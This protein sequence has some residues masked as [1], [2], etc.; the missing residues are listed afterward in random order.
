MEVPK[1]IIDKMVSTGSA[2][3]EWVT[4]SV[5]N[6]IEIERAPSFAEWV[7]AACGAFPAREYELL[8]LKTRFLRIRRWKERQYPNPMRSLW[9]VRICCKRPRHRT[10]NQSDEL[11]PP[12]ATSQPSRSTRWHWTLQ[13]SFSQLTVENSRNPNVLHSPHGQ[14]DDAQRDW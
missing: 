7:N 13:L 4:H 1:G 9:P 14:G 3:M 2:E 5:I 8:L 11:P 6:R 10:T 12:H